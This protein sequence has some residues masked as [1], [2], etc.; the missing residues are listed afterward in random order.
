MAATKV[1]PGGGAKLVIDRAG[2]PQTLGYLR[3]IGDIRWKRTIIPIPNLGATNDYLEKIQG[4]VDFM[5]IP[6][7]ITLDV[8]DL[9]QAEL[10]DQLD[11]ASGAAPEDYRIQIRDNTSGTADVGS[12]WEFDA[13]LEEFTVNP[14]SPDDAVTASITLNPTGEVTFTIASA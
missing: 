11:V 1:V 10:I 14:G 4:Q 9:G 8:D 12:K 13:F 6:A 3:S 5:P 2:T 7:E